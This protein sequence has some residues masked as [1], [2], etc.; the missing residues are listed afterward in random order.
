[1]FKRVTLTTLLQS[2]EREE[3]VRIKKI[4]ELLL[5]FQFHIRHQITSWLPCY[6]R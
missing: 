6:E 5:P 4:G 2:Q 1:M 3:G